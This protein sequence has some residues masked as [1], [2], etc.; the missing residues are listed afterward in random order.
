M[1]FFF[2]FPCTACW[3]VCISAIHCV[4]LGT[5][6][7]LPFLILSVISKVGQLKYMYFLHWQWER[8]L[9]CYVGKLWTLC[10]AGHGWQ[11]CSISLIILL[12]QQVQHIL[13]W[14]REWKRIVIIVVSHWHKTIQEAMEICIFTSDKKIFHHLILITFANSSVFCQWHKYATHY[15]VWVAMDENWAE[16]LLCST[17]WF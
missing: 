2:F 1:R 3:D 12:Y 6:V 8:M 13:I 5:N 16:F 10:V 17:K 14:R 9:L 4:W 11:N 15:Q 7:S